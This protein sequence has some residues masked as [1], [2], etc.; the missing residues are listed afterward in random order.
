MLQ[1]FGQ[2]WRLD[3]DEVEQFRQF[4]GLAQQQGI[5]ALFEA[6]KQFALAWRLYTGI[7]EQGQGQ[8][9]LWMPCGEHGDDLSAHGVAHQV[10]A[11]D[12]EGAGEV[13]QP[14]G[15]G[16]DVVADVVRAAAFT[17]AGQV[18]GNHVVTLGQIAGETRPV[19]LVGAETVDQQHGLRFCRAALVVAD[20]QL[21]DLQGAFAESRTGAIDQLA[22]GE[23]GGRGEV[24]YAGNRGKNQDKS[25]KGFLHEWSLLS[26]TSH[27][28]ACH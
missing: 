16:A 17:E 18:H 24:E 11:A 27:T 2:L 15:L 10:Q 25:E 1:P 8:D 7:V 13:E 20:I 3:E 19:V 9:L 26:N 6:S 12:A 4:L 22:G 21:A 14:L 5:L 28:A 23:Q